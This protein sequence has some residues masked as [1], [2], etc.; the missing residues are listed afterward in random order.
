MKLLRDGRPTRTALVISAVVAVVV[1]V[2]IGVGQ[3][4][5]GSDKGGT[6][7]PAGTSGFPAPTT[8]RRVIRALAV[9]LHR[10]PDLALIHLEPGEIRLQYYAD[11]RDDY[12]AFI[13]WKDGKFGIPERFSFG[14]NGSALRFDPAE[15]R[16]DGVENADRMRRDI[17]LGDWRIVRADGY[18]R[19][20]PISDGSGLIWRITIEHRSEQRY[21]YMNQAGLFLRIAMVTSLA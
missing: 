9:R 8:I 14:G 6:A 10:V 1:A 12:G 18:R 21:M 2:A 3:V 17:G 5:A 7:V 16:L 4:S 13:V 15:L 19:G 20:A 11:G